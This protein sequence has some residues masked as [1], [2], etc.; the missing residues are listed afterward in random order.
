MPPTK[1]GYDFESVDLVPPVGS[2]YLL[3]LFKHP[4]D[5][6]GEL[7]TYLRSPKRHSRLDVG[8]GWG[9]TLVEGFL[10]NRVWTMVLAV[11]ALGSLVF[12]IVWVC[13]RGDDVQSAFGV[14]GWMC[15]LAVLIVGWTQACLE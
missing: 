3:H 1:A 2:H 12:A 6:D 10:A 15:T 13:L 5:Y 14:A 4:E 8:V 9:I 7:I 11:F